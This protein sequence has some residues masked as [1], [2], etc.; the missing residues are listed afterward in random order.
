MFT[1]NVKETILVLSQEQVDRKSFYNHSHGMDAMD[2]DNVF[3]YDPVAQF[4]L[5]LP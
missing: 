4:D 5:S 3:I 1:D 2:R